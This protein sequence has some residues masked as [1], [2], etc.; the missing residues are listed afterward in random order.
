MNLLKSLV[1]MSVVTSGCRILG[2]VRDFLIAYTFGASFETDVFFSIFKIPNLLRRIFADGAFSQAFI[3]VLSE[4][5]THH[6]KTVIK[7]F[8]SNVFG[9][10][11]LALALLIIIGM[12]FPSA[13]VLITSPGFSSEICKLTLGIKL[14]KIIFPYIFFVSI[15]SFISSI[16]YTYNSFLIPSFSP[17]LLN[18]SVIFF[19]IL[20]TFVK[21]SY[22]SPQI[23]SLGWGVIIGGILQIVYQLPMLSIKKMLVLPKLNFYNTGLQKVLKKIAPAI[24]GVSAG[25]ISIVI[26]SIIASLFNSGSISWLY[27][28]DRLMEF[29]IGVL[30]V[31]VSTLIFPKLIKYHT[32]KA[33]KDYSRLLDWGLRIAVALA[34]PSTALLAILSKPFIIALFEYGHFIDFDTV[35]TQKI[36]LCYTLG[37]TALMSIKV[38]STAFYSI[39]DVITPMKISFITLFITQIMNIIFVFFL[40]QSGLALSIS[41]SAWINALLLFVALYKTKKFHLQPGWFLFLT[42]IFCSTIIMSLFLWFML[43]FIPSW[44]IGNIVVRISRIFLVCF[45]S[46]S[47]YLIALWCFGMNLKQFHYIVYD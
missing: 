42:R 15:S 35:M 18:F 5:K 28:A 31:S 17:I 41:I 6:K 33:N 1:S 45:I 25:Q 22:F 21:N 40:K 30:G 4:Y 29:P 37:I 19:T 47:I 2:F 16:L 20:S 3:P 7:E 12:L 10:L 9:V 23:L 13:I 34:F 8:I 26:N 43:Y 24:L 14:F 44:S 27:Y 39:K 46:S 32:L 11:I 36:L 38:L